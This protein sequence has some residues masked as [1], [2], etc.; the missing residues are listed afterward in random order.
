MEDNV[1][2]NDNLNCSDEPTAVRPVGNTAKAYIE[3]VIPDVEIT[4][5]V[6]LLLQETDSVSTFCSEKKGISTD[7]GSVTFAIFT[8]KDQQ[9]QQSLKPEDGSISKLSDTTSRISTFE[10]RFNLV[11]EEIAGTFDEFRQTQ[12]EQ[13]EL[14][15]TI[16]KQLQLSQPTQPP[17][18]NF[19]APNSLPVPGQHFASA[20]E[21]A[22]R[23]S[24]ISSDQANH[25]S[26][27]NQSSSPMGVTVTGN[28]SSAKGQASS[29]WPKATG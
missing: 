1:Y 2:I 17:T 26:Q 8:D 7:R 25:L 18:P 6:P 9:P 14:L 12:T 15:T 23:Q 24:S 22:D 4:G 27:L 29:C 3:V 16:L 10:D 19:N 21:A 28:D 5:A 13:R 11:T 20:T